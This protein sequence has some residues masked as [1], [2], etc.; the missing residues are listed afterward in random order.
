M[1]TARYN[2]LHTILG[3]ITQVCQGL[4]ERLEADDNTPNEP[5][6]DRL[7]FERNRNSSFAEDKTDAD[8]LWGRMHDG[9]WRSLLRAQYHVRYGAASEDGIAGFCHPASVVKQVSG[10]LANI[11]DAVLCVDTGDV[12]LWAGLCISR[13]AG[14]TLSSEH[15]GTMGYSICAGIASILAQPPGATA[16]VIVGDG[17]FQMTCNELAV[18]KQHKREG[19]LL[20]LVV[21]DNKVLGRVFFGFSDA[22]GCEIEGPD[23]V[24]LSHAY[25]GDGMVVTSNDQVKAALREANARRGLFIVHARTDPSIK[26]DMAKFHVVTSNRADSG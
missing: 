5:V 15:L 24:Q 26:A 2:P 21:L 8:I 20:L 17:G 3:D 4:V 1:V 16:V 9:E 25:G 10:F 14:I 22:K 13:T 11:N 7:D 6:A 12:T 19:D 18:F 23:Y